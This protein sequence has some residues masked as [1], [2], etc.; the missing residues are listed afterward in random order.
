MTGTIALLT[1]PPGITQQLDVL[2]P[3][4]STLTVR[5]VVGAQSFP[6]F[7][8]FTTAGTATTIAGLTI[9]NGEAMLQGG[10][11]TALNGGSL[12]VRD[13]IVT[14]NRAV[15]GSSG[16]YILELGDRRRP[17]SRDR[18][19]DP[20]RPDDLVDRIAGAVRWIARLADLVFAPAGDG[21]ILGL[22]RARVEP[23]G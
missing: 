9:T 4:A 8:V 20:R 10:G 15:E 5:R 13:A 7:A 18:F 23:S 22:H 3:G 6:V 17:G 2:G 16:G 21:A 11:I 1:A 19:V 12:T 14:A